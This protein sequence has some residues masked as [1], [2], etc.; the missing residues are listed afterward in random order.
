MKIKKKKMYNVVPNFDIINNKISNMFYSVPYIY[1]IVNNITNSWFDIKIN[2]FLAKCNDKSIYKGINKRKQF[3]KIPFACDSN[4]EILS[5]DIDSIYVNNMIQL[6]PDDEQKIILDKWFDAY[7]KM[8]NIVIKSYKNDLF[9]KCKLNTNF[10]QIRNKLK[11]EKKLIQNK[12]IINNIKIYA[13]T[14]DYAIEDICKNV[15]AAIT[16][17]KNGNIK[18]FRLRYIKQSKKSKIFK[19]EKTALKIDNENLIIKSIGSIKINNIN[20]IDEIPSD[21]TIISKNNR[22]YINIPILKKCNKTKNEIINEILRVIALDPGLRTFLTGYNNK[23]TIEIATNLK[24]KIEQILNDIDK[25]ESKYIHGQIKNRKGIE[26]RYRKIK[27]L[28][29]ELHWKTIKYLIENYDVIMLGNM[30]TKNIASK[31]NNLNEMN[32]RVAMNMRLYVFTKR[33][34]YKCNL[35]KKQLIRV[36][37]SYTSKTCSSCGNVNEGKN[38]TKIFKCQNERCKLKI[39]RDNNGAKNIYII[40]TKY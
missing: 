16:N 27:N 2:N 23:E 34:I 17:K 8:Y 30:S 25:L 18:S 40:G 7:I 21:C 39:D 4:G 11:N 14:L 12:S 6:F 13:H 29:D 20:D 33:L 37:E 19:I 15:Q 32:K 31:E 28:I 5:S 1:D 22:Y 24:E 36:N 35:S 10:M 26:K 38:K 9:N 3:S